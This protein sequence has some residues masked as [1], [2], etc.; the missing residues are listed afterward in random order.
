M[1]ANAMDAENACKYVQKAPECGESES[2]G[3]EKLPK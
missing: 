1:K 3:I 2:R